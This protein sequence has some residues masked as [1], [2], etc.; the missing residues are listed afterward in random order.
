MQIGCTKSLG[1]GKALVLKIYQSGSK[2]PVWLGKYFS[3]LSSDHN[4][5]LSL[6]TGKFFSKAFQ[7]MLMSR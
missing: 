7:T 5:V 1:S 4:Q 3:T 6:H 2:F